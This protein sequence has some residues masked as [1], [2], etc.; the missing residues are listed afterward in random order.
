MNA[1]TKTE[2]IAEGKAKKIYATTDPTKLIFHF[3]DDATAFNAQ[4]KG[5]IE[6]KGVLNQ[7]ISARFFTMLR[8]KGLAKAGE[9]VGTRCVVRYV[10]STPSK[11]RQ[12]LDLIRGLDVRSADQVLQFTE[13]EVARTVRKALAELDAEQQRQAQQALARA[14]DGPEAGA[15]RAQGAHERQRDEERGQLEGVATIGAGRDIETLQAEGVPDG[16]ADRLVV[17]DEQQG[18]LH[19]PTLA[20][21]GLTPEGSDHRWGTWVISSRFC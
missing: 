2:M 17:F 19:R 11:A 15:K 12:V 8:E 6:S 5:T 7:R 13:R 9:R 21:E 18:G 10:R 16:F 3:K 1:P 20:A 14:G 4:K